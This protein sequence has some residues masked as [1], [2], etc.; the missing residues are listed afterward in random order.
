MLQNNVPTYE[1]V[2]NAA[3]NVIIIANPIATLAPN[4]PSLVM[5][6]NCACAP[7]NAPVA[8]IEHA[9]P[10]DQ[11][12]PN[13]A[14]ANAIVGAPTNNANAYITTDVP[15]SATNH[16]TRSRDMCAIIVDV[17]FIAVCA[18]RV[19]VDVDV[20]AN[21]LSESNAELTLSR[22]QS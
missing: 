8:P 15:M 18:D 4:R 10:A 1:C 17:E 3:R 16:A 2:T 22:A 9:P 19:S 14:G 5:C 11:H 6:A 21:V 12:N 13:F 7:R 20:V